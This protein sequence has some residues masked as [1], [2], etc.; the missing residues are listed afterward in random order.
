[1]SPDIPKLQAVESPSLEY[2]HFVSLPLAIHPGL[3]DKLFN[4]QNCILGTSN[5]SADEIIDKNSSEDNSEGEDS[6]Q[7]SRDV[8]VKLEVPDGK[9]RVKVDITSIPI[10]SYPP[11]ATSSS[12]LSGKKKPATLILKGLSSLTWPFVGLLWLLSPLVKM[13][14]FIHV[15]LETLR[16]LS[17]IGGVK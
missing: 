6:E 5:S 13:H 9:E 1:M 11:K 7:E 3:V 4:F 12:S 16:P 10:V 15:C 14:V 17:F 8:A 2:S